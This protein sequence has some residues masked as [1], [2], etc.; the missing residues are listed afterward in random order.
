MRSE[1]TSP[2]PIAAALLLLAASACGE[3]SLGGDGGAG[4]GGVGGHGGQP[5]PICDL[6]GIDDDFDEALCPASYP[7]WR[8]VVHVDG[9]VPASGDGWSWETA[10]RTV[11]EGIDRAHCGALRA[12]VCDQWEVWVKEGTYFIHQGCR[13]D[14]VR[15]RDRVGIY[16]GFSGGE[17]ERHQRDW[18]SH[19]TILDGRD[20]PEDRARVY[21]VVA[22]IDPLEGRLDGFTVRY[23]SADHET[24][25]LYTNGGGLGVLNA[26]PT[27]TNCTFRDNHAS[28]S[29]G[30]LVVR[31]GN[32]VVSHCT[33]EGNSASFGGGLAAIYE[34]DGVYADNH[35]VA[36]QG[37]D[38]GAVAIIDTPGRLVDNVLS[39]NSAVTGGGIFITSG[40]V[41]ISGGAIV[42][43]VATTHS[44]GI[45]VTSWQE[46]EAMVTIDGVTIE[47]N[48]ADPAYRAGGLGVFGESTVV[49][50]NSRVL[51]NRAL[52]GA[53]MLV[54]ESTLLATN[55]AFSGNEADRWGG[56]IFADGSELS[57]TH[58][59]FADN[60]AFD[61]GAIANIDGMLTLR[62]S[63]LWGDTPNEL[64]WFSNGDIAVHYS[65]VAGGFWGDGNLGELPAH[66]PLLDE[67][68]HLEAGSPSIDAA[69]EAVASPRD[70]DGRPR[71]DDPDTPDGPA[72]AP[73]CPDMGAFEFQP[74]G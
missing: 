42:D 72:C 9:T 13:D 3:S 15:M 5:P 28:D 60:L 4:G 53:G 26:S 47:G 62:N 71:V 74:P 22:A 24:E 17:T 2:P 21:H 20:G 67:D 66:D 39:E 69:D 70:L 63:I 31:G 43:N 58:G 8:C 16:G 51:G 40:M 23:G 10:V 50:T 6:Q 46:D 25:T 34:G 68:H 61:G 64:A 37:H 1:S 56:A 59:T 14:F 48:H 55:V 29:G 54:V 44:G 30:G 27:I 45:L 11:Q 12:D 33:F 57:I 32:P 18:Q 41:E 52:D 19:E 38:G 35:F 49:L 36:N 73:P 7:P 65:N